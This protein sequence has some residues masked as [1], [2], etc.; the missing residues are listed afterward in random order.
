MEQTKMMPLLFT[1]GANPSLSKQVSSL[2]ET[3]FSPVR[4]SHFADGEVFA[5][6]LCSVANRVCV[7]VHSTFRPVSERLMD[8]LI[9]IDAL[10]NAQAKRIVVIMP[11]YGYSRQDR[12]VEEGDPISGFLVGKMLEAAGMDE[13]ITLDFHSAGLLSRFPFAHQ[14]LTAIPL[15]AS[16]LSLEMKNRGI[17]AKQTVV[18]SPDRGGLSRAESLSS[19]LPGT[20]LAYASKVRPSPNKAVVEAIHGDITGKVCIVID[21]MIDTAGTLSEVVKT[22][23][24]NGAS[25]VWVAATHGIFSGKAH[26]IIRSCGIRILLVSDTIELPVAEGVT[27]SVAPLIAEAIKKEF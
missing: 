18:V 27:I 15:F 5:K 16:R 13:L 24:T 6:P 22:L 14:N 25:E 3:P 9:F 4:I 1:L 10:K 11:Y 2:L 20:S 12:I 8:L 21:D 7:I 19:L 26:E 23:S 17:D